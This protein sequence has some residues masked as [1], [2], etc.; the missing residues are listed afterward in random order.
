V[1]APGARNNAEA[2]RHAASG[3][4][5][6][7]WENV[8]SESRASSFPSITFPPTVQHGGSTVRRPRAGHDDSHDDHHHRGGSGTGITLPSAAPPSVTL[9][10]FD[11]SLST[12]A[13]ILALS[14]SLAINLLL[15][16]INGIML[17]FG[18]IAA[19]SL[20]GWSG[21]PE[22]AGTLG[23]RGAGSRSSQETQT[24]PRR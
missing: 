18:E 14:S 16:F 15:P 2:G 21:W 10:I 4:G 6:D 19:K 12:R 11:S 17:G 20:F 7:N 8:P 5:E 23:L 13:R 9:S 22:I 3:S 24:P 1:L